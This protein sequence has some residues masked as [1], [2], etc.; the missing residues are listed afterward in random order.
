MSLL[1]GQ[2]WLR[3]DRGR[4]ELDNANLAKATTRGFDLLMLMLCLHI[5]KRFTGWSHDKS[6]LLVN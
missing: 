1:L 4:L 5:W 2:S 3:A 6:D